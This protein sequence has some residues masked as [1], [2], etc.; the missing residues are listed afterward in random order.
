MLAEEG[1]LSQQDNITQQEGAVLDEMIWSL[2]SHNTSPWPPEEGG[3][4]YSPLDIDPGLLSFGSQALDEEEEE[5]LRLRYMALQSVLRTQNEDSKNLQKEK[6]QH[7]QTLHPNSFDKV[8]TSS[9]NSPWLPS[10]SRLL[11]DDVRDAKVVEEVFKEPMFGDLG[12]PKANA[13]DMSAASSNVSDLGSN[14]EPIP[15]DLG[16]SD[17]DKDNVVDGGKEES[18][19]EEDEELLRAR[20]LCEVAKKW[21]SSA[22]EQAKPVSVKPKKQNTPSFPNKMNFSITVKNDQLKA[23]KLVLQQRKMERIIINLADDSDSSEGEEDNQESLFP[24]DS[25]PPANEESVPFVKEV[26]F[27]DE[28]SVPCKRPK[29]GKSEEMAIASIKSLIEKAKEESSK[30]TTVLPEK[31]EKSLSSLGPKTIMCDLGNGKVVLR[32]G[33][34]QKQRVVSPLQ[35]HQKP[36]RV[37]NTPEAI[38]VLPP[39][40]VKEYRRLKMEILKREQ[41]RKKMTTQ[42]TSVASA[43]SGDS[44]NPD[45]TKTMTKSNDSDSATEERKLRDQLLEMKRRMLERQ[46]GQA[47]TPSPDAAHIL[48]KSQKDISKPASD[49]EVKEVS[50]TQVKPGISRKIVLKRTSST[51]LPKCQV[52]EP[53]MVASP[54]L[55][56]SVRL[57]NS[58]KPGPLGSG[59]LAEVTARGNPVL[60][61]ESLG[62]SEANMKNLVESETRLQA[63]RNLYELE[64]KSMRRV[65]D[66][67]EAEQQSLKQLEQEAESLKKQLLEMNGRLVTK[68][69]HLDTIS[70][71]MKH[72]QMQLRASQQQIRVLGKIC[73]RL[74]QKM[75]GP[76]YRV[77]ALKSAVTAEAQA[78]S[79]VN[80]AG[81]KSVKKVPVVIAETSG[82]E[83]NQATSQDGRQLDQHRLDKFPELGCDAR[84]DQPT[85]YAHGENAKGGLGS[86]DASISL[87]P[88]TSSKIGLCVESCDAPKNN[89][90][91]SSLVVLEVEAKQESSDQSNQNYSQNETTLYSSVIAQSDSKSVQYIHIPLVTSGHEPYSSP[92]PG[93]KYLW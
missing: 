6:L 47:R 62:N 34:T 77:P 54:G 21:Q 68:R 58:S 49:S 87:C 78:Q 38:Q 59:K 64:R 9:Q 12:D 45:S 37:S 7:D 89:E 1:E 43:V 48:G 61:N 93:Q 8:N 36:S 83:V 22:S 26:L 53:H 56:S 85:Q 32:G 82:Q 63:I 52:K 69:K 20:L 31:G 27:N 75:I 55:L 46:A 57:I 30:K 67:A 28:T 84:G 70:I 2:D 5:E 44:T 17:D 51:E 24:H 29:D 90:K 25:N 19:L 66:D 41:E 86:Q 88:Q 4:E 72:K 33:N 79:I 92:I 74:G 73:L 3:D 42:N 35:K 76:R 91:Q 15:M 10:A 11:E 71:K 40:Q 65:L 39:A 23:Q 50:T 14:T 18:D 80:P 81:N 16:S 60:K 13:G